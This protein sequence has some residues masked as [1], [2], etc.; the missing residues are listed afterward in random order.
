[1]LTSRFVNYTV[2][3]MLRMRQRGRSQAPR[4]ASTLVE[5]DLFHHNW[6]IY[7][8]YNTITFRIILQHNLLFCSVS[9]QTGHLYE[10]AVFEAMVISQH[11]TSTQDKCIVQIMTWRQS[12]VIR[13]GAARGHVSL[14]RCSRSPVV[15]RRRRH[16]LEQFA[17]WRS[18]SPRRGNAASPPFQAEDVPLPAIVPG[19]YI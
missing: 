12:A 16:C 4:W 10:C 17:D 7:C 3:R 8:N 19:Y 1:M 5:S 14:S 6:Q 9:K 11:W 15:S 13:V 18:Y 2:S